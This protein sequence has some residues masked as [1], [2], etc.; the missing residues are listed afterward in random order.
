MNKIAWA[1]GYLEGEGCFTPNRARGGVLI[2][3]Q[4]A[5]AYVEPLE[6]LVEIFPGTTLHGPYRRNEKD[7]KRS[8]LAKPRY[9]WAARGATAL[10]VIQCVLPL[11][12]EK[13]RSEINRALLERL[14][15]ERVADDRRVAGQ[16]S[17]GQT[18]LLILN[19]PLQDSLLT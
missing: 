4:A 11:M 18:K 3:V 12:S 1:A 16:T 15:W 6:L 9:C 5:S 13:R 2:Q 19:T 7:L 8:P 17:G 10:D 14:D